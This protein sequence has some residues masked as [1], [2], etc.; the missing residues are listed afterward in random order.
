[1]NERE[2][3]LF[4]ALVNDLRLLSDEIHAI[5]QKQHAANDANNNEAIQPVRIEVVH[6]P[7]VDPARQEYYTAEN[8]ERNSHWRRF[9]PWLEGIG[10]IAA[11][12]LALLTALT[13]WEIHKQTPKIAESADAAKGASDTAARTLTASVEQFRTDERA[14]IELE[15]F[16][17]V[18]KSPA[19]DKFPALFRYSIY[20]KNTGKTVAYGISVSGPRQP[21]LS[22]LTLGD[23][24][25]QIGNYQDRFLLGKFKNGPPES[26]LFR[27][28]PK[29]L[30]PGIVSAVPFDMYGQAPIGQPPRLYTFLIGRIDY[31]DAFDVE[32]WIKFCFYVSNVQGIIENCMY[33]NDEDR[34]PEVPASKKT[35][36]TPPPR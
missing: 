17:G 5:C 10:V 13:F 4:R 22:A 30:G 12:V 3:Q 18:L 26:I 21:P 23:N 19:S 2:L 20:P 36:A 34:N 28:I 29:T 16:K 11:F 27:R 1:M 33:G 31:S 8:R 7:E 14:R 32:H 15:P 25:E 35:T 6:A 9:R 24:P